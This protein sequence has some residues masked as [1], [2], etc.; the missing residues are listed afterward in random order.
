M[1]F[2]P[3]ILYFRGM[4]GRFPIFFILLICAFFS[5]NLYS[6]KFK[7]SYFYI[8][9][10]FDNRE[11]KSQSVGNI[12]N[13]ND[14]TTTP[15]YLQN[16]II[17]FLK[18]NLDSEMI[19]KWDPYF[20][21]LSLLRFHFQESKTN[22][23]ING[24]FNFSG[25]F[26]I[27]IG[28]D[29]IT[30]FPFKYKIKY[31]RQA[32]EIAELNELILSKTKELNR[33]LEVW[34]KDNYEKNFKLA[35]HVTVISTDFTPNEIDSDTLYYF[36]RKI[37]INDFTEKKSHPGRF[38]A[39][40]F[41][42]MG[43]QANV[44]MSNDTVYLRLQVKV[45]QIKGMSWILDGSKTQYVLDHEQTHFDISQLV[46][47]KFKEKLREEALPPQNYDSRLQFLYLDYFRMINRMQ[48]VYD[49]E[50]QHGL[51]KVEQAKWEQNISE[52]LEKY[53]LVNK[54]N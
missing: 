31:K 23:T 35:R 26:F 11:L 13:E 44:N 24:E 29:S 5:S 54:L 38:A 28:E 37:N 16:G 8:G 49:E 52:E 50:T 53:R 22:Q 43:Y 27:N 39:A 34:F 12:Y 17:S 32:S 36:Q 46:A 48:N 21:N 42:N 20:V 4:I 3:F 7:S 51:N 2:Q 30:V 33:K 18:K 14:E 19:H 1:Y 10:I 47:E 40:I 9:E 25:S 41:T 6:Q 45:Y 15:F